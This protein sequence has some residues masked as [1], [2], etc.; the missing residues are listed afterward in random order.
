MPGLSKVIVLDPDARAG[1]QMQ[2]GFER[3]GMPVEAVASLDQALDHL[4]DA[5]V[6]IAGASRSPSALRFF[7][8]RSFIMYPNC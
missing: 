6:V 4:A 2:L 1:R 3:E 8:D 5:C 7:P